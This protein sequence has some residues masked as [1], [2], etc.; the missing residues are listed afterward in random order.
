MGITEPMP[1]VTADANLGT[2]EAKSLCQLLAPIEE[3]SACVGC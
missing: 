1:M 3:Q 2:S